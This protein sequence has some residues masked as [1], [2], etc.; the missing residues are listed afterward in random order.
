[1]FLQTY[2]SEIVAK[3][4]GGM[5]LQM[6]FE[7]E[8]I[9]PSEVGFQL[10]MTI[11]HIEGK[12]KIY[13][14]YEEQLMNV[15]LYQ[16]KYSLNLVA[17]TMVD[18]LVKNFREWIFEYNESEEVDSKI[19]RFVEGFAEFRRRMQEVW[20][21]KQ[22]CRKELLPLGKINVERYIQSSLESLK[23]DKHIDITEFIELKNKLLDECIIVE[24]SSFFE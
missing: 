10:M 22:S 6:Q 4:L 2:E 13:S 24:S 19:R 3:G 17:V 7:I 12:S 14:F 21:S 15:E 9:L 18:N 1:M 20:S 11:H 8:K 16:E 23:R 5:L